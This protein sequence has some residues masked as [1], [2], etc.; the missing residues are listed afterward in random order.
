M[1]W[2]T[3]QL[4]G[5]WSLDTVILTPNLAPPLFQDVFL[6]IRA[7]ML[8]VRSLS[9]ALSPR[10]IGTALYPPPNLTWTVPYHSGN[11]HGPYQSICIFS[12]YCIDTIFRKLVM[13]CYN[14]L[15]R[16]LLF[17][18]VT[19]HKQEFMLLIITHGALRTECLA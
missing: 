7:T 1:Q 19:R 12:H 15:S 9:W 8:S 18:F 5:Q 6:R 14:W 2:Q 11:P 4:T 16:L 3:Q 17:L 13:L 10:V